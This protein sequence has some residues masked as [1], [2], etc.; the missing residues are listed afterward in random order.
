MAFEDNI[1]ILIVM[2]IYGV[3]SGG[4]AIILKKGIFRA[5]GL[6]LDNFFKDVLPTAWN[7]L[8]T[9]MWF[10]GGIAALTG[11]LI[12][13]VA[14]NIYDVSIVKPLI[15][16]NLLFTFI[17]AAVYF[18]ERLSAVEWFGV[19]VLILGLVLFAFSPNIESTGDMNILLLLGFLPITLGLISLMIVLLFA[20]KRVGS[21]EFVFPVFAGMFFGLGTFFT[22]SLL[23]GLN[24]SH[25]TLLPDNLLIIYSLVMLIVTYGFATVAQQ[26]AFE[27]GRLSIVSP[28]TNAVSITISFIGAYFV[29]YEELVSTFAGALSFQSFFKLTG[30]VCIILALILLRREINPNMDLST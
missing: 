25:Q 29:F 17:F 16:T 5:G 24:G 11:F 9:P 26:L 10:L 22:K 12:Y 27:K 19:G 30:L 23:I 13:T 28:I 1:I 7:L 21:A 20:L 4:S 2:L 6:K 8:T 15:N 18:K 3:T 14:L